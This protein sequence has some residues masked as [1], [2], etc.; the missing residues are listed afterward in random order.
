MFN[1]LGGE[2]AR[3]R[4]SSLNADGRVVRT[5]QILVG[6]LSGVGGFAEQ[7]AE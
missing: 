5:L 7:S 4:D 2:V 1:L 3:I 6:S